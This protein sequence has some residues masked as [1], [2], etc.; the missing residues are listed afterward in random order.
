MR[1]AALLLV[2]LL[3]GRAGPLPAPSRPDVYRWEANGINDSGVIVG[4]RYVARSDSLREGYSAFVL[5]PGA[6]PRYFGTLGGRQSKALAINTAG[7]VAGSSQ[8][9][10]GAWHAFAFVPGA[11]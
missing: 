1:A 6:A 10:T 3:A 4:T 8:T 2:A 11:G 7:H 9:R 5:R